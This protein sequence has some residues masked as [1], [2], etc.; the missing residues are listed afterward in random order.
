M[1]PQTTALL[2]LFLSAF[3]V[4]WQRN[5]IL[6]LTTTGAFFVSHLLFVFAGVI[7]AP[8][9]IR[10][11]LPTSYGYVKWSLISS[12]DLIRAMVII[13]GGLA[14]VLLGHMLG[15]LLLALLGR[16]RRAVWA[17]LMRRPHTL[18]QVVDKPKLYTGLTLALLAATAVVISHSASVVSGLQAMYLS[19][20]ISEFYRSRSEVSQFGL[21]YAILVFN[22]LPFLSV[23]AWMQYRISRSSSGFRWALVSVTFTA[24]FLL[25]TFQKRPLV[26][27]LITLLLTHSLS[28]IY[29]GR[30]RLR[31][32][33]RFPVSL[34]FWLTRLMNPRMV[35]ALLI[36]FGVLIWLFMVSTSWAALSQSFSETLLTLTFVSLDRIF[37]RLAVMPILYAHYFPQVAPFYGISNIGKLASVFGF[38]YYPDTVLVLRYFSTSDGAGAIGALMDFYSAFG[39]PGW[40]IL[41]LLLGII[42]N[43]FD[44]W[45]YSLA[46]SL[47]N[48]TLWI[49]MMIFAY[50][51]SQAS[52][53]RS[54]SSYG[55]ITFLLLWFVL[56]IRLRPAPLQSQAAVK[57][58]FTERTV[59]KSA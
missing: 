32:P 10:E 59:G 42:L 55:G 51:L 50:Y 45:L 31:L 20:D 36:P 17:F 43:L 38:E 40:A 47:V 21:L 23:L 46:P 6:D 44:R 52:L 15:D 26:L 11:Y 14:W 18:V 24:F 13:A 49:F 2:I 25:A 53:A 57:Q 48:R 5:R 29:A 27:Y 7:A 37:G 1:T 28:E 3:V 39:W 41:S 54:L 19:S 56:K 8:W 4:W 9:L 22:V 33:S 16:K 58:L 35:L 34:R 30:W 12:D